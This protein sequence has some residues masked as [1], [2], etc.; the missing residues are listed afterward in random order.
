M[1]LRP[2]FQNFLAPCFFLLAF[3][4]VPVGA[5]GDLPDTK[6][7]DEFNPPN[8]EKRDERR[9]DPAEDSGMGRDIRKFGE[10]VAQRIDRIVKKKTFEFDGD[11]WTMQG[12][13][14]VFPSP[15]TGFNLGLRLQLQNIRRQDPHEAE[16]IAQVLSS[17]RGRQKHQLQVDF[18][19]A[20]HNKYRITAR[21]AY[22]RDI[23]FHYFGIG[24]NLPF[25]VTLIEDPNSIEYRN[26]RQGPSLNL[27]FFRYFSRYWRGGPFINLKWTQIEYPAGSLIDREQPVG[28]RGGRTHSLG[29]AL[30]YDTLDF[31]PYPSRGSYHELFFYLYDKSI[32]FSDYDFTR[33]TYTFR[34]FISL[35]RRLIFAHRTLAEWL[36]GNVPY[37]EMGAVGG[38]FAQSA[39]GADLFFRGYDVNRFID[40]LRLIL[41]FEL[42]WD[43]LF[44]SFLGQDLT[45]GFVPFFDIGRVWKSVPESFDD[46][47]ASGG[48]GVRLIWNSRLVVRFDTAFTP[49]GIRVVANIGNAF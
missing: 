33:L 7:I 27:Q 15:A 23:S 31:E 37:Y 5:I 30:I 29:L 40:K 17:D 36:S 32:T 16:I 3:G 1:I 8:K 20:L 21:L 13:P 9:T 42:R 45:V 44:T 11:P 48:W 22:D 28:I 6:S 43:P 2:A 19:W 10:E 49:D 14:I 34:R 18:P 41:G 46:W 25:S 39:I 26:I 38:T 35:H 12:I 4:S 24:N 47:H